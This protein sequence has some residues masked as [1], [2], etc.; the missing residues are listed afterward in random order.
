[1]CVRA[2][3][4]KLCVSHVCRGAPSV[5]KC[6][7]CLSVRLVCNFFCVFTF[8]SRAA[9]MAVAAGPVPSSPTYFLPTTIATLSRAAVVVTVTKMALAKAMRRVSHTTSCRISYCRV[10]ACVLVCMCVCACAC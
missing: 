1:V 2:R 8:F 6:L 3:V 5:C 4:C 10:S 7:C 9:L